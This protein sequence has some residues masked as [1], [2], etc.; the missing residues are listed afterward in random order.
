MFIGLI[1][2]EDSTF[3]LET[4]LSSDIFESETG[5]KYRFSGYYSGLTCT[6]EIGWALGQIG[7]SQSVE[8]LKH[9]MKA[10]KTL[11]WDFPY[12]FLVGLC[13]L[14]DKD[15]IDDLKKKLEPANVQEKCLR[16]IEDAY[17]FPA[18]LVPSLKEIV[19]TTQDYY[20]GEMAKRIIEECTA[21][22]N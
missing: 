20:V 15:A 2:D 8:I 1:G 17:Y 9:G 16:A 10:I 11:G 5:H 13:L 7:G 3:F 22:T 18:F 4:V 12:S 6:N 14:S 21:L 19:K